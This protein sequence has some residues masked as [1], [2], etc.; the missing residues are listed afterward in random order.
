MGKE[1]IRSQKH[2][3]FFFMLFFMLKTKSALQQLSVD[4]VCDFTLSAELIKAP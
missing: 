2:L 1:E 4:L 3:H